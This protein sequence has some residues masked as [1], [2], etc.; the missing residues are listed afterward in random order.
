VNWKN[1]KH[2][3][4]STRETSNSRIQMARA[5][6]LELENWSF[7]GAWILALGASTLGAIEK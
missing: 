3:H 4:P 2:Q 7:S 1:S 5:L 6:A